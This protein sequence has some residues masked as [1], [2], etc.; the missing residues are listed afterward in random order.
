MIT[1]LPLKVGHTILVR[2]M[3]GFCVHDHSR[4]IDFFFANFFFLSFPEHDD[5]ATCML[6]LSKLVGTPPGSMI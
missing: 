5:H 6:Y 1:L 3:G 4:S 2:C